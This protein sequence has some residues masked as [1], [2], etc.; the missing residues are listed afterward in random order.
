MDRSINS[1][2]R[3]LEAIR[4]GT[5]IGSFLVDGQ[6]VTLNVK[7]AVFPQAELQKIIGGNDAR[8]LDIYLAT[9]KNAVCSGEGG[10]VGEC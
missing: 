4:P 1:R 9:F 3:R 6:T 10:V 5:L 7:D 2:L 8:D